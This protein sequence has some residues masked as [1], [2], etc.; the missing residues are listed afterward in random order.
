MENNRT[1]KRLLIAFGVLFVFLI[2]AGVAVLV[3]VLLKNNTEQQQVA[4]IPANGTSLLLIDKLGE[5]A[6]TQ[7]S[8]KLLTVSE[9]DHEAKGTV[10][11]SDQSVNYQVNG[12]HVVTLNSQAPF[13]AATYTPI[14]SQLATFFNDEGLEKSTYPSNPAGIN[15][16]AN[17]K[18]V[19]STYGAEFAKVITITCEDKEVVNQSIKSAQDLLST[20][21]FTVSL[22][23]Q[24]ILKQAS[25]DA[26]AHTVYLVNVI[27]DKSRILGSLLYTQEA[28][29]K[30]KFIVNV[31]AGEGD[32]KGGKM[33]QSDAATEVQNDANFGPLMSTVLGSKD[34]AK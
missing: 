2:S 8:L 27:S 11:V 12:T 13:D 15:L 23:S 19:C 20:A 28:S 18:T 4:T 9:P 25:D 26:K 17:D 29:D 14:A 6:A 33:H 16:Y 1:K 30:A 7:E 10:I 3:M 5:Y 21:A 31:A 24:V 22:N 32:A 34:T